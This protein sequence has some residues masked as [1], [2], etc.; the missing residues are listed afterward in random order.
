MRTYT[1]DEEWPRHD[2]KHW[3][4]AFEHAQAVG[5]F[6][7]HIDAAHRFGT[8]RCPYGCHNVKVDHTAVGGDMFAASLPNKIRA[9]QKANGLD[10]TSIKLAEAT[11]LMDTAEALID[12]IEEGLTSVWSKQCATEELDRICLQIETA[13]TTLQDEVLARAI[14]AEDSATEVE[15]LQ[16][17]SDEAESHADEAEGVL[18][19][20][21]RQTVTRPLRGR[22]DGLRD[23]LANVCKQLDALD[24]NGTTPL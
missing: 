17:W 6:L 18:K 16:Q 3:R 8:L 5:W 11:R 22:L 9:C 24:G 23:R 1:A 2:K 21:S 19:K 14:A 4:D 12:R 15:D 10:P 20:V 7:D 13:D